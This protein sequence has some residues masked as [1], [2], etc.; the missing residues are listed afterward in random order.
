MAAAN[1][2]A[3]ENRISELEERVYGRLDKDIDYPNVKYL[4]L[5]NLPH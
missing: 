1:L 5:P 3:L 4:S 2:S